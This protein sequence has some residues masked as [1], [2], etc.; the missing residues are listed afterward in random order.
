MIDHRKILSIKIMLNFVVT[1]KHCLFYNLGLHHLI[2]Q[3]LTALLKKKTSFEF[4]TR[5]GKF[6]TTQFFIEILRAVLH[7]YCVYFF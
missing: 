6:T 1:V 5:H 7:K 3:T 2:T 4:N